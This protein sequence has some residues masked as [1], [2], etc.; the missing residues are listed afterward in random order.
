MRS[1]VVAVG[2]ASERSSRR[3]ASVAEHPVA[4]LEQ[5]AIR[6]DARRAGGGRRPSQRRRRRAGPTAI[7]RD[8]RAGRGADRGD[9]VV[10]AGGQVDDAQPSAPPSAASSAARGRDAGR[11][12]RARARGRRRPGGSPRSG[13]RRATATRGPAG[14]GGASLSP[15]RRRG[16][17][18]RRAAE[19]TP[20]GRAAV[21][22][23]DVA[24]PADG[25]LV[26]RDRDRVV[27][28]QDHRVG[29]HDVADRRPAERPA[30][31]PS[32]SRRGR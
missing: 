22:D 7:D 3:R 25:H 13:R 27:A 12:S 30:R 10:G 29:G 19:T 16:A 23:R 15:A 31:R 2:L 20:I 5:R 11:A 21:D 14:R 6:V 1:G 18:T 17:G 28:A 32:G 8:A 9:P 24:E 26:D 4:V